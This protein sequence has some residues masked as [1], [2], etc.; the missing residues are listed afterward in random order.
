MFAKDNTIPDA[1]ARC[2]AQK[3]VDVLC[4][5]LVRSQGC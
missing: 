2:C 4:D 1:V 5:W 3:G